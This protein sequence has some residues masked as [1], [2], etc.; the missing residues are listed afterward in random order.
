MIV[1]FHSLACLAGGRAAAVSDD[2]ETARESNVF[3]TDP[4]RFLA[5]GFKAF[6]VHAASPFSLG[7]DEPVRR[8]GSL[9]RQK[10]IVGCLNNKA[11]SIMRVKCSSLTIVW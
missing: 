4:D 11:V 8:F 5:L 7:E 10:F 9:M 1:L 6:P 2:L 3:R